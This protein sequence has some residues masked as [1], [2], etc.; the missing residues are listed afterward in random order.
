MQRPV[1]HIDVRLPEEGWHLGSV[2]REDRLWLR[3]RLRLLVGLSQTGQKVTELLGHQ[4]GHCCGPGRELGEGPE[5][6]KG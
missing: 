2:Y 3:R 1:A 6:F 5:K 4:R